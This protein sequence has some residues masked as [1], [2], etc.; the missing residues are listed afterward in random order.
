MIKKTGKYLRGRTHHEISD[1]FEQG[2]AETKSAR[3]PRHASS[4]IDGLDLALSMAAPG[5]AVAIMCHEQMDEMLA[6]LQTIGTPRS[7]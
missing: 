2:V 7:A 5:D 4:E 1:L 6:R 3:L